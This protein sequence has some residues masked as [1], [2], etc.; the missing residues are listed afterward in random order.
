MTLPV[1]VVIAT[2]QAW[3]EAC[4]ALESVHA[5]V[6]DAGGEVVV[7]HRGDGLPADLA[8]RYPAVVEVVVPGASAHQLR[9]AALPRTR[10]DVVAITE[11]HCV[12]APDWVAAVLRAHRERPAAAAIG[13]AVENGATERAID[14]AAYFLGNAYAM[15]PV[16]GD[17]PGRIAAQANVSYK[18]RALPERIPDAG[19]FEPDHHAALTARGEQVCADSRMVVRHDQSLGFAGT[20]AINFHAARATAGVMGSR[21]G[22]AARLA[23]ALMTPARHPAAV[24]L[25]LRDVWRKRRLR[26]RLLASSPCIAL[27]AACAVAGTF[28]G[29]LAGPGDSPRHIR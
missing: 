29:F 11:D 16:D 9:G 27:I 5:Q 28:T 1:S 18:R 14:W 3:P 23:R 24:A 13:G 7:A 4:A 8:S 17:P 25:H 6:V 26:R 10:G 20:L 22:A 21:M 12:V 2:T 19:F 15:A